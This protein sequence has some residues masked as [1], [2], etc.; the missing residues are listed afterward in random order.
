MNNLIYWIKL[1]PEDKIDIQDAIDYYNFKENGLGRKFYQTIAQSFDTLSQNPF[2]QIRYKN[3][4]CYYIKP[5]PFLVHYIINEDEK[6]VQILGVIHTSTPPK[7][8]YKF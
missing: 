3:I 1:E 2:Y 6:T 8:S 7:K 5:F 4:R